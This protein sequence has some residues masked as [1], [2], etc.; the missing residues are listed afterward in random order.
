[1]LRLFNSRLVFSPFSFFVLWISGFANCEYH[2]KFVCE[3]S[4]SVYMSARKIL[5]SLKIYWIGRSKT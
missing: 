1:M 4:Y 3:N 5:V 2:Y